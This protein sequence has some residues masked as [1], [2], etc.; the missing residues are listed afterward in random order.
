MF[1]VD[2][3]GSVPRHGF[4]KILDFM[5]EFVK[6]FEIGPAQNQFQFGVVIFDHEVKEKFKMS[7]Y[8][9]KNAMIN[10]INAI[11]QRAIAGGTHT[12]LGLDFLRSTSFTESAGDRPG[13]PN[14]AIVMTDGES[15][16]KT[17]TVIA[18]LEL[19]AAYVKVFGIGIG[20]HVDEGE[21]RAIAS[22][23]YTRDNNWWLV[24]NFSALED[25][26]KELMVK[27]CSAQGM[28]LSLQLP[29]DQVLRL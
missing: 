8:H 15:S 13:V 16:G 17:K 26:K 29:A 18:A 28:L 23:S 5:A 1:L 2:G 22:D 20:Q 11:E 7:A 9:D 12:F 19:Q 24:K 25:I 10:A 6:P 27:V 14:V 4:T 21:L 3:S